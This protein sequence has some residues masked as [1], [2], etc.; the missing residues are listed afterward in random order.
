MLRK[1]KEEEEEEEGNHE[2]REIPFEDEY[3]YDIDDDN[4][5]PNI[6]NTAL[7]STGMQETIGTNAD[8]DERLLD[9]WINLEP[10][11]LE[12]IVREE[13]NMIP[14]TEGEDE[15]AEN[16]IKHRHQIDNKGTRRKNV[17]KDQQY[18]MSHTP[19]GTRSIPMLEDVEQDEELY[20]FDRHPRS[21]R[22]MGQYWPDERQI[23]AYES[24]K[25]EKKPTPV[26]N[27]TQ[28]SPY[29]S[30]GLVSTVCR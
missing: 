10:T 18:H 16:E 6:R 12:D 24:L 29:V 21:T 1:N 2:E 8:T 13:W 4:N 14:D 17:S 23:N 28:D 22:E 15:G 5:I 30:S 27:R 25:M 11:T 26:T 3:D 9:D 19:S 20:E 7:A